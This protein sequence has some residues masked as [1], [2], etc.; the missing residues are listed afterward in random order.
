MEGKLHCL[1][2]I[3]ILIHVSRWQ[4]WGVQGQ[5]YPPFHVAPG[6]ES[7]SNPYR[8]LS[9]SD[10]TFLAL[11]ISPTFRTS[12]PSPLT[13]KPVRSS[14][15][16]IIM[17]GGHMGSGQFPKPTFPDS[18][19][20]SGSGNYDATDFDKINFPTEKPS[21]TTNIPKLINCKIENALIDYGGKCH[22]LLTQG[23]CSPN[24]WFLINKE[25]EA[26]CAQRP[27]PKENLLYNDRCVSISDSS[28]CGVSEML[29]VEFNGDVYCDC[30]PY[31]V[32]DTDARRCF[33]EHDRGSCPFGE[34]LDLD[35]NDKLR[36]VE[37]I[38]KRDDLIYNPE[39]KSCYKKIFK[40]SCK[41]EKGYEVVYKDK[42]R[43]ADCG[44]INN[45]NIFEVPAL[46]SCPAGSRRDY[47]GN[48][49]KVRTVRPGG[50]E[51]YRVPTQ[52]VSRY[53]QCPHGLT[54]YPDGSCRKVNELLG[55]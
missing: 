16:S 8:E 50:P 7:I 2:I 35:S 21:S 26:Y 3:Y 10:G 36:C 48:C 45:R 6:I 11:G 33:A 47:F 12:N 34:Y 9:R 40:G 44:S 25:G 38:C 42:D 54:K 4:Y 53:S 39:N 41:E 27:C 17:P 24:Q 49:Q 14:S 29:Y 18:E 15:S 28:V 1:L 43:T 31:Y 46:T 13:L 52:Q 19:T 55:R 23:P 5:P 20:G 32:Y 37:N 30:L 22:A 51:A